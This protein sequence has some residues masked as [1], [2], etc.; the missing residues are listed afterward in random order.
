MVLYGQ[1][2]VLVTIYCNG[3]VIYKGRLDFTLQMM[4][5]SLSKLD[6]LTASALSG[7]LDFASLKS[8][9][10]PRSAWWLTAAMCSSKAAKEPPTCKKFYM[11]LVSLSLRKTYFCKCD[12]CL[13]IVATLYPSWATVDSRATCDWWNDQSDMLCVHAILVL[14]ALKRLMW[15]GDIVPPYMPCSKALCLHAADA[16]HHS[17][18]ERCCGSVITFV[19]LAQNLQL[20]LRL[21]IVQQNAWEGG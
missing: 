18:F 17:N 20:Y 19:T 11:K 2:M 12:K 21:D 15:A 10:L 5:L 16:S 1:T 3:L 4:T 6:S 8:I 14:N 9:L 7:P 13:H